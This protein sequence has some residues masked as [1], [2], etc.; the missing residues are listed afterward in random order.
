MC[1]TLMPLSVDSTPASH[2]TL[3][4]TESRTATCGI[5][6]SHRYGIYASPKPR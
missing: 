5:K 4:A 2:I 3:I 1:A 6:L